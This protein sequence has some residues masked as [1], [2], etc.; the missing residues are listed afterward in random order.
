M[1]IHQMIGGCTILYVRVLVNFINNNY[2]AQ[3]IKQVY[4]RF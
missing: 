2:G 4:T 1:K 3:K